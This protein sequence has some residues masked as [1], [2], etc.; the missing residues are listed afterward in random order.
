MKALRNLTAAVLASTVFAGAV[1]PT[2]AQDSHLGIPIDR[3]G[4]VS[5]TVRD[6]LGDDARATLTA[7]NACGIKSI[8]FSSPNFRGDVPMFA[9][10]SV[11]DLIAFQQEFG[12]I[13]PSLGI[14]YE[15]IEENF[16]QLMEAANAL[17][18]TY[19]RIS[20]IDEVEGET[21]AEYFHRLA[22]ALNE[23]GAKLA[24]EG[25]T[26][27]YHNHDQEFR[28]VGG[29]M[30][31]YDILLEEVDPANAAF[32]MD[33]Y[34]AVVGNANPIELIQEHP[35]RFPLYHVKDAH[36]VGV[37]R[38]AEVTMTTPGVGFIDWDEFF[39]LDDQS[40]VEHY[41]IE[42]DRPYPD[43]V[44]SACD[45]YAYLTATDAEAAEAGIQAS[46]S[47]AAEAA[48]QAELEA[49]AAAAEAAEAAADA[50]AEAAAAAAAPAADPAAPAAP[51]R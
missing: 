24:A 1:V 20:G 9:N 17:G 43:G 16:D 33:I 41:F 25:I 51:A 19:M 32:E 15:H 44:T 13:V 48:R 2:L 6:M 39:E 47:A 21:E 3:V 30:A 37:G 42:N 27:A 40:G 8:E 29:G 11:P 50:A 23:G 35:G 46:Q 4:V 26:L 45:G 5:F 7:L 18:A 34:W 22:D 31:G 36:E 28:Y 49:E 12:F 38:A 14:N 10:V